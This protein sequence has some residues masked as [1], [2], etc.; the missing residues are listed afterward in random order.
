MSTSGYAL[1]KRGDGEGGKEELG[2]RKSGKVSAWKSGP[3]L[4]TPIHSAGEEEEEVEK[5]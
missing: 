2:E 1:C 4:P 5:N 3:L